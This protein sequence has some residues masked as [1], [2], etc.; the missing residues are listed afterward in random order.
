MKAPSL[1]RPRV[2][3]FSALYVPRILPLT[4]GKAPPN[5]RFLLCSIFPISLPTNISR[6]PLLIC[7]W[8]T[9]T[10]LKKASRGSSAPLSERNFS[11]ITFGSRRQESGDKIAPPLT[12]AR[13]TQRESGERCRS[14]TPKT[15]I[16]SAKRTR[17]RI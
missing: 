11:E 6:P 7:V 13:P 2:M 16:A 8:P 15:R 12:E 10:N 3:S 1:L 9:K 4:R 5:Q 14:N 17:N